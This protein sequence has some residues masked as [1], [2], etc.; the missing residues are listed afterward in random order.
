MTKSEKLLAS[1]LLETAAESY[2]NHGCNDVSF[3]MFK[4]LGLEDLADLER[5]FNLY[6]LGREPAPDDDQYCGLRHIG[7]YAWMGMMAHLLKTEAE[8]EE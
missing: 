5:K 1:R 8:S 4:G 2:S 6:N 7:D 3:E